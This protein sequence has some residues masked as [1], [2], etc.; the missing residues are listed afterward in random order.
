MSLDALLTEGKPSGHRADKVLI[1]YRSLPEVQRA[2]FAELIQ[3]PMWS[4]PQIAE[5]LRDMGH[6]IQGD[7]VRNFRTKLKNGRVYL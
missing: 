5:A 4:A 2:A 7:Q 3:D 6:D 1:A